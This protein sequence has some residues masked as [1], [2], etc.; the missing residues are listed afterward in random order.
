MDSKLLPTFREAAERRGLIEEDNTLNKSLAEATG[1]MMSYAK[2]LY[3][4]IDIL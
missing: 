4:N 3:N 2:A 1:C